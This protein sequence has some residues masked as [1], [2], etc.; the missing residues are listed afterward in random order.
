MLDPSDQCFCQ[1]LDTEWPGLHYSDGAAMG[2]FKMTF[3][4]TFNGKVRLPGHF[5]S[6]V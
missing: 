1:A 4:I 2:A 6:M 3:A 5:R